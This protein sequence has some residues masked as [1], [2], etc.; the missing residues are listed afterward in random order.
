MQNQILGGNS[1]SNSNTS[2]L[3]N[4]NSLNSTLGRLTNSINQLNAAISKLN[5][6]SIKNSQTPTNVRN[7]IPITPAI[8]GDNS[9]ISSSL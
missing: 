7:N 9:R 8:G 1:K 4:I 2:N 5:N 3:G 6:V